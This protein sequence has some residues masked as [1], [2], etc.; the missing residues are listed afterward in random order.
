MKIANL[1]Q[2]YKSLALANQK[3][4]GN[5]E[6][7]FAPLHLGNRG[8]AFNWHNTPEGYD[9]WWKVTHA[10][11]PPIPEV[12]A[13]VKEESPVVSEEVADD[14]ALLDMLTEF[15]L[16]EKDIKWVK[17]LIGLPNENGI[18]L[19]LNYIQARTGSC[20]LHYENKFVRKVTTKKFNEQSI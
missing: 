14:I 3:A 4:Q 16:T 7:E 1:P 11:L 9:F 5:K 13:E 8:G 10:S 6:D 2:P 20:I 15:E 19:L 12:F 18:Q 17:H